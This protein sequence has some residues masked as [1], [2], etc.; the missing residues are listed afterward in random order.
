[1]SRQCNVLSRKEKLFFENMN[2]YIDE[3]SPG[4]EE[5]SLSY[6]NYLYKS[7]IITGSK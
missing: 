4:K 7:Q 1:V 5:L 3:E 2:M 6:K